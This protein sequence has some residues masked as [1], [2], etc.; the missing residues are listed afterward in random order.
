MV[1][2][3]RDDIQIALHND[4]KRIVLCYMFSPIGSK[5][6]SQST[7]FDEILHCCSKFCRIFRTHKDTIVADAESS[8]LRLPGGIRIQHFWNPPHACC[9]YAKAAGHTFKQR[10]RQPLIARRQNQYICL[11]I[12]WRWILLRACKSCNTRNQKLFSEL[13]EFLLDWTITYNKGLEW[14]AVIKKLF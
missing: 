14:Y 2:D 9:N 3:A 13:H 8:R 4:I 5:T 10:Q 7:I 12:K 1:S 6:F 11:A